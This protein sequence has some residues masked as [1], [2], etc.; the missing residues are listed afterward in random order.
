MS[1]RQ[2]NLQDILKWS[3]QYSDPLTD[4]QKAKMQHL[5]PKWIDIMFPNSFKQMQEDVV[6]L[7][8][9]FPIQFRIRA[10]EDLTDLLGSL[11]NA[12]D[13]LKI[14]AALKNLQTCLHTRPEESHYLWDSYQK[15]IQNVKQTEQEILQEKLKSNP[16]QTE[17]DRRR[18]ETE[19]EKNVS[20]RID[21]YSWN[22]FSNMFFEMTGKNPDDGKGASSDEFEH[23]PDRRLKISLPTDPAKLADGEL[24]S[25][26]LKLI[27]QTCI[28]LTEMGQNH[29][30][31][32]TTLTENGWIELLCELLDTTLYPNLTSLI[33]TRAVS[34]LSALSDQHSPALSRF[35]SSNG[36]DR[37]GQLLQGEDIRCILKILFFVKKIAE[38]E[39]E[40]L[41]G[42]TRIVEERKKWVDETHPISSLVENQTGQKV[43]TTIPN[44]SKSHSHSCTQC[45]KEAHMKC[46][47]CKTVWYCG[48][49]CQKKH[50]PIHSKICEKLAERQQQLPKPQEMPKVREA[51]VL[52]VNT[53][54]V[55]KLESL[56]KDLEGDSSQSLSHQVVEYTQMIVNIVQAVST[57]ST[58]SL[59]KVLDLLPSLITECKTRIKKD[60]GALSSKHVSKPDPDD[61]EPSPEEVR[62]EL[63]RELSICEQMESSLKKLK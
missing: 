57:Y 61:D 4:E 2:S 10:A 60:L 20:S 42:L 55:Q 17:D 62:E 52:F 35:L 5:D 51:L 23:T 32:Q 22:I 29:P 40:G 34:A 56:K 7:S 6:A 39:K 9:M 24:E 15:Y 25:L 49:E 53:S 18:L 31:I 30:L 50:Y 16:P 48:A 41:N 58:G 47:R 63:N 36:F 19:S 26:H 21:E 8:P 33:H 13:L 28:C 59:S 46:G 37:L 43:V 3:L 44:P 1:V 38:Y 27:E 12:S 11:D 54:I 45:G 14:P